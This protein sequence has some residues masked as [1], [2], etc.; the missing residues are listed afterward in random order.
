MT[1][2]KIF[3][4]YNFSSTE[5]GLEAMPIAV[6][7][8]NEPLDPVV[9][10]ADMSDLDLDNDLGIP[11]PND[12]ELGDSNIDFQSDDVSCKL[13]FKCQFSR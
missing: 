7:F 10:D 6:E 11:Q 3:D 13:R 2:F 1:V 4:E 9:D 12:V 5:F 8:P